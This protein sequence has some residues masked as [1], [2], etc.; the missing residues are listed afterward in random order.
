[1]S[2]IVLYRI[3]YDEIGCAEGNTRHDMLISGDDGLY[4]LDWICWIG[5]AELNM[6]DEV[7]YADAD[8]EI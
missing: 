7:G 3:G 8:I 5:S 6:L 4:M 1:V 2:R